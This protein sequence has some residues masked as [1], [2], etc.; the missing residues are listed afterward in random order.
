MTWNRTKGGLEQKAK[1]NGEIFICFTKTDS[2][3]INNSEYNSLG[4][5]CKPL[6]A[7]E[8]MRLLKMLNNLLRQ[9]SARH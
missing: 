6:L 4:N 1:G 7:K 5:S 3:Y 8:E 2:R 9:R